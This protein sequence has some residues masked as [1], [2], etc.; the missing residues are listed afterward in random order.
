MARQIRDDVASH[1]SLAVPNVDLARVRVHETA[2]T[3]RLTRLLRRA[4]IE[5]VTIGRHVVVAGRLNESSARGH[6]LLAH[7]LTHVRQVG[8]L[9]LVRFFAAYFRAYLGGR[10]RGLSHAEAYRA[11]PF[12]VEAYRIGAL[13]AEDH[14]SRLVAMGSPKAG[15]EAGVSAG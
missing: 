15:G 12:E 14:E 11:N 1:L 5:A 6:G 13:A 7:E 4:K 2:Q 3:G 8:E 9:G 10:R